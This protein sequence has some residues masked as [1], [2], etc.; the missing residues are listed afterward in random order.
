MYYNVSRA[1]IDR[2]EPQELPSEITFLLAFDSAKVN[3]RLGCPPINKKEQSPATVDS[4][5]V[6]DGLSRLSLDSAPDDRTAAEDD[7]VVSGDGVTELI[8]TSEPEDDHREI[9]SISETDLVDGVFNPPETDARF[10]PWNALPTKLR[11]KVV[12]KFLPT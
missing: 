3:L 12:I 10:A 4:R 8:A 5:S 9:I 2:L 7:D 1:T 6:A 11:P